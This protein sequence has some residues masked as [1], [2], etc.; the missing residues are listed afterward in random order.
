MG[1]RAKTA[2]AQ[3]G[4]TREKSQKTRLWLNY[5][6]KLITRPVIWQIVDKFKLV[7]NIRHASVNEEIGIV[8][9]ELEGTRP[10]I[11]AAI[12]WLEK[13]GVGVEPVEINVIES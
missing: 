1:A 10:R 9:L 12:K 6:Q 3:K 7:I 5:P 4:K 8:C 13:A 2:P 11:K